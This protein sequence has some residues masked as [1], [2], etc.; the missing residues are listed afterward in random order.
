M[1]RPEELSTLQ[2]SGKLIFESHLPYC[3]YNV[4]F[5]IEAADAV[6]CSSPFF[7]EPANFY[8]T[9]EDF[10]EYYFNSI[11]LDLIPLLIKQMTT[12]P[13][14]GRLFTLRRALLTMPN[15]PATE[16]GGEAAG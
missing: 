9:K 16:D 1:D 6:I 13:T 3:Y 10:V 2:I 7:S 14:I 4:G 8:A 11:S 5:L 12:N 15:T